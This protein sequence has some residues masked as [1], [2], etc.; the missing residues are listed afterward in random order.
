[1]SSFLHSSKHLADCRPII[2]SKLY[3]RSICGNSDPPDVKRSNCDGGWRAKKMYEQWEVRKKGKRGVTQISNEWELESRL[4][5]R[6][7]VIFSLI[8]SL[9]VL[10]ASMNL[11]FPFS[12]LIVHVGHSL[13]RLLATVATILWF[14]ATISWRLGM[15]RVDGTIIFRLRVVTMTPYPDY[16]MIYNGDK[17]PQIRAENINKS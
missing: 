3:I 11:I 15:Q 1:M 13:E 16:P 10:L 7:G 17:I 4:E 14:H 6:G 9:P 8:V 5:E 2:E 12:L